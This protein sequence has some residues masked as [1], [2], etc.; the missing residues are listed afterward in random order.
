MGTDSGWGR[1][2]GEGKDHFEAI[3]HLLAHADDAARADG[4]ARAARVGDGVEA[5]LVAAGGD[6]FAVVFLAGVEVVIVGV[7]AGGGKA[8][9]LVGREHAEGGADLE[10]HAVD[11]ADEVED[12][13]EFVVIA[14]VTP[15]R[16]HAEARAA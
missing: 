3:V 7:E 5:V 16:T 11:G 13:V 1:K 4:E 14:D 15:G 6:D 8:V 2:A 12:V 10:A 9:G